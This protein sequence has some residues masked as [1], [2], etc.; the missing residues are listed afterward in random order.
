MPF[1]LLGRHRRRI[2]TS[3]CRSTIDP[4]SRI[5]SGRSRDSPEWNGP[6]E[7]AII[8]ALNKFG[9]VRRDR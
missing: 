6:Y 2:A 3:G 4:L 7:V 8:A 9:P 5:G 1:Y